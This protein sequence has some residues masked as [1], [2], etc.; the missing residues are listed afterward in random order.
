MEREK[1][2]SKEHIQCYNCQKYGHYADE[3]SNPKVPRKKKEEA[4]FAHD[5]DDEEAVMSVMAKGI[6]KVAIRRV[7]G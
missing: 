1:K 7:D 6:G 3:C 4:Q 5:F 2:K